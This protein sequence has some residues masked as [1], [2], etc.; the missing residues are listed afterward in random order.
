MTATI[1]R[2]HAT[3]DHGQRTERAREAILHLLSEREADRTIC[4]S[5]A[6]RVLDPHDF[7]PHMTEVRRVAAELCALGAVRILQRGQPVEI[8]EARGPIRLGRGPRFEE[9]FEP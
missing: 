1:T 8:E 4:P 6:A 9:N 5:E 7:R 2:V 3:A